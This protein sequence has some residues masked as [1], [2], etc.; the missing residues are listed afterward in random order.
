M[1]AYEK[2]QEYL[3]SF[4]SSDFLTSSD[5]LS[6]AKA[7]S[8]YARLTG[9]NI[10]SGL[11]TFSNAISVMG[12]NIS[13]NVSSGNTNI[14][15]GS[16]SNSSGIDNMCVGRNSCLNLSTGYNNMAVG[17]D[18]LSVIT[19]GNNNTAIGFSAGG[20]LLDASSGNVNIGLQSSG[21]FVC[22]DCVGIGS[23]SVASTTNSVAIGNMAKANTLNSIAIG[24]NT[25]VNHDNSIVIGTSL[26]TTAINQ[27][28]LG[29]PNET[30]QIMGLL[31]VIKTATFT[32]P[33]F[34]SAP[35]LNYTSFTPTTRYTPGY[36]ITVSPNTEVNNALT[37]V[38][39]VVILQTITIPDIGSYFI[40]T[41]IQANTVTANAVYNIG[42]VLAP[43]TQELARQVATSAGATTTSLIIKNWT[44]MNITTVNSVVN[45]YGYITTTP[46]VTNIVKAELKAVRL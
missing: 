20:N 29:S 44:H 7:N 26:L 28:V 5:S 32:L 39:D 33:S 41:M 19:T 24:Y 8:L 15:I 6:L 22:Q 2:P 11:N 38:N 37:V 27:I 17:Y 9:S 35:L 25:I 18:A 45:V 16:T 13:S 36:T 1:S 14:N 10:M 46:T 4:S 43:T 12:I 34:L 31:N 30:T 42:I 23:N 21:L 40:E 3:P